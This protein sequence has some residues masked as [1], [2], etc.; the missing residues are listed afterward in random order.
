M[1]SNEEFPSTYEGLVRLVERLRGPDGC[2]WDREQTLQSLVPLFLEEC[3]E[4]VEAIEQ[5]DSRELGEELGDVLFHLALQIQLGGES[6]SL[7]QEHVFEMLIEKLVRRHPHVFGDVQVADSGE[8]KANWAA[9]KRQEKPDAEP[10]LLEGV[11]GNMPALSQAQQIQE[12][13]GRAEFDWND[14][15]GVLNKVVEEVEEL[16]E[17][18]SDADREKEL[19]DVLF[20]VVNVARW[21]GVDAE[22]ALRRTNFRFRRR[23]A[24]MEK[25]SRERGL[26]FSEVSLDKKEALWQ[27]AKALEG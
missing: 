12:R 13:A 14:L 5:G 20:S 26:V 19:G 6:G 23:F 10:S 25:L 15:R 16:A 9:I 11:P 24:T 1:S 21:L 18:E 3:Y 8:V 27:E 2:P 17:A 7:T 22:G 4:L